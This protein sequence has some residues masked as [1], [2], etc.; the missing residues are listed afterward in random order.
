MDFNISYTLVQMTRF[1]MFLFATS[2]L[3]ASGFAV[4]QSWVQRYDGFGP[5]NEFAEAAVADSSGNFY[6][7]GRGSYAGND[8][9]LTAKYDANGTLMW[10]ATYGDPEKR[11]D[12]ASAIAIDS[13]GNVYVTG[14]AGSSV[15]ENDYATLKYDADGT[16]LWNVTYNGPGNYDDKAYAI[17]IDSSGNVYVTGQSFNG[18]GSR[19]D[20]STIKYDSNGNQLWVA[21]YGGSGNYDD[22]ANAIAVDGSGN[23]YVTGYSPGAG[24]T[25]D[26]ATIKY[27]TDGNQLWVSRYNGPANNEDAARAIAVDSFG[28]VY[29]TGGSYGSPG[30]YDYATIKYNGTDGTQLWVSRY[31]GP[32]NN[33]DQALAIA[34]D[35]SANV[36]VTGKSQGPGTSQDYATLKYDTDG[37][38]QWVAR[39]NG[40]VSGPDEAYSIAVDSSGNVYVAGISRGSPG[41]DDYATVKYDSSGTQQW[42]ERYNGP[43]NSSDSAKS[44]ALGPS[45]NIYVAGYSIGSSTGYDFAAINYDTDGNLTWEA[46]YN[47]F[48]STDDSAQVSAVD[49]SNNVYVA[50]FTSSAAS[51][52]YLTAKY[53]ANGA[54]L[55]NAT[56]NGPANGEDVP[57]A[58]AVDSSGNSYVTGESWGTGVEYDY[59][60]VKYGATGTQLWVARYNGPG[61][62]SDIAKALAVDSAGNIYVTG[63]SQEAG[64]DFNTATV[65][66]APNGTELWAQRYDVGPDSETW[67]IA[68]D[69]SAN[70]YVTGFSD[71]MTGA[72]YDYM[73]IKYDTDGNQ[74]W[75]SKYNGP[76]NGG[77]KAYAIAADTSGN[78]YVTG[79]SPGVGTG[80][81]Y[82]TVKYDADGN[83]LWAARY[84]N[85]S[86]EDFVSRMV[87]DSSGN[88][89]VTGYS[90]VPETSFDYTTV[91]YDA[92][93]NP[94]WVARYDYAL[95]DELAQA[96][97]VDSSGGVYVTGQS[98]D[99]V[100]GGFG[101][102]TVKYDSSGIQQ[103]AERYIGSGND[104][105][106]YS[107]VLGS[108]GSIYVSGQS[109]GLGTGYD[110][111]VI[112]YSEAPAGGTGGTP[113]VGLMEAPE[114][115]AALLAIFGLA[116]VIFAISVTIRR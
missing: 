110:V 91:K 28:D 85:A 17:T 4:A 97:A 29:V 11:S 7:T 103:W 80:S 6:I 114:S 2:I 87:I 39:Y 64:G 88:V 51:T 116:I 95:S 3:L 99:P 24:T 61:S 68:L 34:L 15:T 21:A 13:S 93:G 105:A 67:A 33:W 50:G 77:D 26:Y 47:G 66:Y 92:D 78:V 37:S 65:K 38:Q 89:Y 111:A 49:S 48:G 75:I 84:D 76:A 10:K 71:N 72:D 55:W 16:L 30:N 18:S 31:N 98:V 20:Y 62:R 107:V 74:K 86:S 108:S 59:A 58:I 106:A 41:N 82:A 81:D 96:I 102:A 43:G 63:Y 52:D 94:L 19:Y 8:D 104:A 69:S 27:D 45:A 53:D 73:T 90:W 83:Q 32:G 12:Y 35:P 54:L 25:Y 44:I 109:L 79:N 40:P 112:K 1:I 46:R 100:V 23:V 36:Y 113:G 56:Y 9:Y 101:Y 14:Y 115:N 42:V 57:Y 70:V 5:G 22:R 60:T